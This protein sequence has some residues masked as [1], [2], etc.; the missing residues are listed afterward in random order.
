[1]NDFVLRKL[2]LVSRDGLFH[3]GLILFVIAMLDFI[4][5][6]LATAKLNQAWLCSFGLTKTFKYFAVSVFI[7]YFCCIRKQNYT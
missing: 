5:R 6:F 4:L 2:L 7:S 3:V 1:M